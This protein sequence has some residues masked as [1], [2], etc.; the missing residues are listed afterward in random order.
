MIAGFK[1]HSH[2]SPSNQGAW[3]PKWGVFPWTYFVMTLGGA[4]HD[5]Q[6]FITSWW[7]SRTLVKTI[8]VCFR[9]RRW[10]WL[11]DDLLDTS[12]FLFQS[13]WKPQDYHCTFPN[14]NPKLPI[15]FLKQPFNFIV[16]LNLWG[17]CQVPIYSKPTIP[18]YYLL[19]VRYICH[20]KEP[21]RIHYY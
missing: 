14:R 2:F 11:P 15:I 19:L 10:Q 12:Y 17:N 6:G 8:V 9:P 20:N 5:M 21:M 16:V 18:Y 1:T 4:G 13:N 3:Y 7:V